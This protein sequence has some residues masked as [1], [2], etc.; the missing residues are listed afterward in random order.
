MCDFGN[1]R[2]SSRGPPLTVE[3]RR[4]LI[5]SLCYFESSNGMRPSPETWH[6]LGQLMVQLGERDAAS[7]AFQNGLT[8][9]YGG[10]DVPRIA[11]ARMGDD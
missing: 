7:E 11:D 9:S 3:W 2:S 1:G 10:A 5:D 8:L 6:E 4:C